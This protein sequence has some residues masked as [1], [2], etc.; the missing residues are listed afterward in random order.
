MA[1]VQ[2]RHRDG[3]GRAYYERKAAAGKTSMEAMRC[4]KRRLSGIVYHQMVLDARARAAGRED[5]G[6]GYWL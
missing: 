4:L 6:G 2:F 5:T 1:V 3:L